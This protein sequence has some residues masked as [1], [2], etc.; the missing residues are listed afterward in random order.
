MPRRCLCDRLRDRLASDARLATLPMAAKYL[1][2]AL[3]ERAAEAP[4]G[5]LRLGSEF[6]FFTGIAMLI[7]AAETEVETVWETLARRGLVQHEGMEVTL[8]DLPVG[9]SA[10]AE[11]AR[12]NGLRGG[13]RRKGETIEEM[14]ARR[15]QAALLLPMPG[16][17]ASEKPTETERETQPVSALP[18][19]TTS[20][21]LVVGQV[22]TTNVARDPAAHAT[23]G[24]EVAEL[25]DLDPVRQRFDYAP[26]REWLQAG[27]DRAFILDVVGQVVGKPGYHPNKVRSLRYFSPALQ[28]AWSAASPPPPPEDDRP[29]NPRAAAIRAWLDSG[30]DGPGPVF[31]A[32]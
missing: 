6:G 22:R 4:D 28:E 1:W 21:S 15:A 30:M 18:T 31:A 24:A 14:R 10:R 25:A 12:I 11:A 13:R 17:G 29:T 8:P 20:K 7:Q 26:V 23:I 32:A 9:H 5:V 16:G 27:M 19:T 3:A 2:L